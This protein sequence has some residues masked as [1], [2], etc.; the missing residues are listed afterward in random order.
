MDLI[1]LLISSLLLFGFWFRFRFSCFLS[2]LKFIKILHLSFG[3][4]ATPRMAV[5]IL[6][7]WAV[8]WPFCCHAIWSGGAKQINSLYRLLFSCEYF[9]VTFTFL[10][11]VHQ[12]KQELQVYVLVLAH[13]GISLNTDSL[14]RLENH[15]Y[16]PPCSRDWV[17]GCRDLLLEKTKNLNKKFKLQFSN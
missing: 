13:L 1:S 14:Y 9:L 3:I 8:R 5:I 16:F 6:G 12:N 4:E 15:R 17:H 10:E 7:F 11:Y 2:M